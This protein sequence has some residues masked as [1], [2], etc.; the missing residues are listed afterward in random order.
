MQTRKV[1]PCPFCGHNRIMLMGTGQNSKFYV[2]TDCGARG[3]NGNSRAT[4]LSM[5]ND[6]NAPCAPSV[7]C[8]VCP[9]AKQCE[10]CINAFGEGAFND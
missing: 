10:Q 1:K 7:Y 6:R 5:W 3:P 4:A 2:C 8:G 9:H